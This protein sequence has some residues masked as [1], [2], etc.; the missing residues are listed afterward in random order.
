[1]LRGVELEL[2]YLSK[3]GVRRGEQN[4]GVHSDMY[5][6]QAYP[7]KEDEIAHMINDKGLSTEF[8]EYVLDL[9]RDG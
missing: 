2:L 5:R 3:K 9:Q 7:L 4:Q 8:G 1:M 6:E